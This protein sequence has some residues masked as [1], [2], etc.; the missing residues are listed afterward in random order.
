MAD[1]QPDEFQSQYRLGCFLRNTNRH[2]EAKTVFQKALDIADKSDNKI[3]PR[4]IENIKDM[5]DDRPRYCK[6]VSGGTKE[7]HVD[8][9]IRLLDKTG[10]QA[11]NKTKILDVGSG[12]GDRIYALSKHYSISAGNVHGL[13]LRDENIRYLNKFFNIHKVDLE[14]DT[15]PFEDEHFD[16]IIF[17]QVIEHLKNIENP[18]LEIKRVLKKDGLAFIGCPNI[19][20]TYCRL[21]IMV[22]KQPTVMKVG[23]AHIRG[24]TPEG[25][26]RY[27]KSLGFDIIGFGGN[28][29]YPLPIDWGRHLAKIL[30][31]HALFIYFICSKNR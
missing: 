17:N 15:F 12:N 23:S 26:R 10:F 4:L 6:I 27:L 25:L 20:S 16:L 3:K 24:F 21:S 19:A 13:E 31:T 14:N 22:G 18:L 28:G 9:M 11:S 5:I 7:Y 8:E 30:P 29:F 1:K 2:D